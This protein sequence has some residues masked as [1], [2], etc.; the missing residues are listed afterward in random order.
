M[1]RCGY[2]DRQ[3]AISS[4]HLAASQHLW[5]IKRPLTHLRVQTH[6]LTPTRPWGRRIEAD[7]HTQAQPIHQ[8]RPTGGTTAAPIAGTIWPTITSTSG[9]MA[10]PGNDTASESPLS[11]STCSIPRGS[12]AKLTRTGAAILKTARAKDSDIG[13]TSLIHPGAGGR[14]GG[15]ARRAAGILALP[16]SRRAMPPLAPCF[17]GCRGC[18]RCVRLR[19]RNLAVMSPTPTH[20]QIPTNLPIRHLLP[21]PRVLA[22]RALHPGVVPVPHGRRLDPRRPPAGRAPRPTIRRGTFT[23]VPDLV[24]AIR[25]FVDAPTNAA[26]RSTGP[27]PL[28]RFSPMPT[29]QPVSG[30]SHRFDSDERLT[31]DDL[32]GRESRPV[33]VERHQGWIVEVGLQGDHLGSLLHRPSL[34]RHHQPGPQTRSAM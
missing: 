12:V 4:R 10:S 3:S 5:T 9:M 21:Q 18:F 16:G 24:A 2:P 22:A 27:R 28:I 23:S 29:G 6:A 15:R 34:G 8:Q 19:A 1:D 7:A 31:E 30:R 33:F 32:S 17:A 20:H 25:T 26:N 13:S 14:A 11:V